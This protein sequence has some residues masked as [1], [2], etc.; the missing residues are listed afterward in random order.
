MKRNGHKKNGKNNEESKESMRN[1]HCDRK[2]VLS[3]TSWEIWAY[4]RNVK[5]QISR[6]KADKIFFKLRRSRERE[7]YRR[8]SAYIVETRG[9][10]PWPDKSDRSSSFEISLTISANDENPTYT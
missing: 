2:T 4:K 8:I 10:A 9:K 1:D 6:K 3:F 5:D 7:R